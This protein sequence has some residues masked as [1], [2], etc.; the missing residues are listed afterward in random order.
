MTE[1]RTG[2]GD[3]L[4]FGA[5][6]C[7][8]EHVARQYAAAGRG[9]FLVARSEEKLEIVKKDLL[10]RGAARVR[11]AALDLGELASLQRWLREDFHALHR[12]SPIDTVLV[13]H[14]VLP[15]QGAIQDQW[16]EIARS[17][18]VN[19]LS[20]LLI[21]TELAPH[22]SGGVIAVITSVAGDRGRQSNYI[23]GAAKGGVSLYLQG[24][25]NRFAKQGVHILDIRPGFVDTPMT[26][27][28]KKGPLFASP[29]QVASGI[30]HA[31]RKRK[32][33]VYLPWFWRFILFIIKLIPESLF[34]KLSL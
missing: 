9:L 29:E 27:H 28:V 20:P 32:D 17:Y 14:G 8:A 16:S 5:T 33:I 6:S 13:A 19:L 21:V 4:I 34:K 18:D 31:V 23:Y 12:E 24:V 3:I 26:A 10:A 11:T 15:D 25:R 22:L 7:I 2:Q 1:Q 30:V